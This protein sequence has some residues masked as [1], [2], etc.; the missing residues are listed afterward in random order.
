MQLTHQ[1]E[2]KFGS[3]VTWSL[4]DPTKVSKNKTKTK[5]KNPSQGYSSQGVALTTHPHLAP[6]LK[7]EK[8][9]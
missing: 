5:I 8:S 3:L 1:H 2:M 7:K 6:R 9:Y 4:A